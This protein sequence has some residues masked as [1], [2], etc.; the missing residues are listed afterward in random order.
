MMSFGVVIVLLLNFG[1]TFFFSGSVY[2][3][4]GFI[5]TFIAVL[6]TLLL[7]KSPKC[8][9][10]INLF[11]RNWKNSE[12][13][14][15]ESGNMILLSAAFLI[16]AV[17]IGAAIALFVEVSAILFLALAILL[18][19]GFWFE[20][21]KSGMTISGAYYISKFAVKIFQLFNS[22]FDR[23]MELIVKFEFMFLGIDKK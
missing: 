10:V 2:Y 13:I 23:I 8:Y 3:F 19:S 20:G 15:E 6:L 14:G 1:L 21:Y 16:G 5:Y 12:L 18:A 9:G 7:R 4:V 22:L 11:V 17:K